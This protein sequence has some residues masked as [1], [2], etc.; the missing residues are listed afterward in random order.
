[1]KIHLET[2]KHL[3]SKPKSNQQFQ[4]IQSSSLNGKLCNSSVI[5]HTTIVNGGQLEFVMSDK[6]YDDKS[7][8][9]KTVLLRP[10][11]KISD[12]L[13]IPSPLLVNGPTK[14]N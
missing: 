10:Q 7:L 5:T 12:K 4:Y 9:V 13:I 3:K 1:M 14:L 11:K 6:F 8:F 2:A